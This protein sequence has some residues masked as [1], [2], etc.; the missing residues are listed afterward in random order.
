MRLLLKI[1]LIGSFHQTSIN[2]KKTKETDKFEVSFVNNKY[3]NI[4]YSDKSRQSEI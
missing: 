3:N 1:L 4:N 2:V